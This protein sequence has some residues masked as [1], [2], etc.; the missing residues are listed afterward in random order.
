M[1]SE[2]ERK[3]NSLKKLGLDV[4]KYSSYKD[5]D[6]NADNISEYLIKIL[7]GTHTFDDEVI[8]KIGE[9]IIDRKYNGRTLSTLISIVDKIKHDNTFNLNKNTKDK[10]LNFYDQILCGVEKR[11]I[12]DDSIVNDTIRMYEKGKIRMYKIVHKINP[13]VHSF[14][15]L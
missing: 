9:F 12:V 2:S 11:Y 14:V 4:I 5:F 7:N 10:F 15:I 6:V 3:I 8:N 13:K 1:I